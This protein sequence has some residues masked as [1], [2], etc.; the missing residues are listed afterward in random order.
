LDCSSLSSGSVKDNS[1]PRRSVESSDWLWCPSADII[2]QRHER[3]KCLELVR[4]GLSGKNS[5]FQPVLPQRP[6]RGL[7]CAGR[8]RRDR[9]GA[10]PLRRA[11]RRRTAEDIFWPRRWLATP[12]YCCVDEPLSNLD[13]R[14]ETDLLHLVDGVGPQARC[15]CVADRHNINPLLPHLDK[16]MYVAN[17][18]GSDW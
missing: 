13:M 14:R 18:S 4:L 15:D 6:R 10:S 11:V 8:R 5:G 12:T 16:V 9:A 3:S 1:T 2:G 17:G 7:C